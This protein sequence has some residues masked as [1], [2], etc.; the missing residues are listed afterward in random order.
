[1]KSV[2]FITISAVLIAVLNT[3]SW[4][5]GPSTHNAIS[6]RS[7]TEIAPVETELIE[8]LTRHNAVVNAGSIFP[9]IY[10]AT[11]RDLAF[12]CHGMD[13]QDICFQYCYNSFALPYSEEAEKTIAFF[14]G[15][16]NHIVADYRWHGGGGHTES[17]LHHAIANDLPGNSLAESII[18]GGLDFVVQHYDQRTPDPKPGWYVPTVH[19]TNILHGMGYAEV[20]EE[21]QV[22]LTTVIMIAVWFEELLEGPVFQVVRQQLPW[23]TANYH[24]WPY[25]GFFDVATA[26]V[27][28]WETQW[29]S[30]Q[31]GTWSAFPNQNR[32]MKEDRFSSYLKALP[33]IAHPVPAYVPLAEHLYTSGIIEVP[34]Q[35]VA[36]GWEFGVPQVRD[37]AGLW[38]AILNWSWR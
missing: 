1:M 11:R 4:S 19:T 34:V 7:L 15:V 18:E 23:T 22:A 36:G 30:L 9:D 25:G 31:T 13:F 27:R 2:Y 10:L 14:M 33:K 29:N 20:N 12:R 28:E 37:L 21:E 3:P 6:D 26:G 35:I 24:T 5:W 8:L 32:L 17:C 38:Q 16:A